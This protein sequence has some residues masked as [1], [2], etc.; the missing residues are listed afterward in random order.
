MGCVESTAPLVSDPVPP[1]QNKPPES[2]VN[3]ALLII[4]LLVFAPGGLCT[5]SML[6]SMLSGSSSEPD[7]DLDSELGLLLFLIFGIPSIG[8]MVFG[9]WLIY[10]ALPPR[11]G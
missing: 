5:V 9:A 7:G 11:R 8:L 1:E 3:V 2:R 10:T 6:G 4:G